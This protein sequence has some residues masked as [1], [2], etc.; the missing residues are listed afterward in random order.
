[1]EL[2][3]LHASDIHFGKPFDPGAAEAFSRFLQR[4]S[5]DLIVLSGD[6]TQRAKVKEYEAAR[7]FLGGLPPVP[8]VV[9]PGNHDVPLYR[10]WERILAPH[11]NYREYISP[12]L[13]NVTRI[14]G[15]TVVSLDSTA[16][17]T[18][19]VNGRFRD[20]QLRFAARAFQESQ[21]GEVK[22][23]VAHHNLARA[24]D[25][26]PEQVLPGHR[27]YLAA[28]ARMGVELVLGGHLHRGYVT[29]SLDVF[30]Q[31]DGAPGI[32]IVHS[33]TTT[34]KRGRARERGQNSLNVV[35]VLKDEIRIQPHRFKEGVDEFFPSGVISIPRER[36]GRR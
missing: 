7:A 29:S 15:A 17:Y 19:I 6:F 28:F 23:L 8:L 33:G 4:L 27:R 11:K 18:A 9:T 16:P 26:E 2:T 20:A 21:E 32:A 24:P 14:P 10:V 30:P 35:R 12:E 5:P 13:D 25:Y 34:S 1:M 36:P 3:L 31:A 22:I